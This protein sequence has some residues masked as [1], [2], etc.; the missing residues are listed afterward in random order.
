MCWAINIY[1]SVTLQ[2]KIYQVAKICNELLYDSEK[3]KLTK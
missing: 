2:V 1:D 3:S